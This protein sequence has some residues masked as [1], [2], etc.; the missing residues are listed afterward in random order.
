MLK[1]TISRF[2]CTEK[3]IPKIISSLNKKNMEPIL[4]YINENKK[5]HY[6]NFN[7]IKNNIKTY[8]NNYFAV[9]LSSLNIQD[10]YNQAELYMNDL[11]CVAIENNCK[12]LIDAENFTIQDE[13]NYM[14]DEIVEKY[15]KEEVIIYKTYQCY[16]KDSFK[17]LNNDIKNR[18]I[19]GDYKIGI[20]LVRGAYYN[21]DFKYGYL[22]K[23]KKETDV[24]YDRCVLFSLLNL[25]NMNDDI[26]IAT[27]NKDSIEKCIRL[28]NKLIF[29]NVK[30]SQLMGMSDE[31][32]YK[33]S[34]NNSVLK[35]VPYGK[36][37]D[38]IPYLVRRLYENKD[39]IKYF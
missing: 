25:D 35:Y 4:D 37:S 38:S 34:K 1:N 6:K 14:T 11:A 28:Q 20:K 8:P 19:Y 32:S 15:N 21:E 29:E 7:K 30:Y 9:K 10:N 18:E 16:K 23:C 33:I 3:Q 13:I 26:I 36:L 2:M 39:M 17:L 5:D 27:H 22:Y 24:N 31:L 12:L